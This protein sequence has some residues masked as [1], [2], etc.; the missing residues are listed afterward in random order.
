MSIY[1]SA[2]FISLIGL[3]WVGLGLSCKT[4]FVKLLPRTNALVILRAI[5]II[6]M[7]AIP[8]FDLKLGL[9][10]EFTERVPSGA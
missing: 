7:Y 10:A 3:G 9:I 4:L 5:Y 6:Q 8:I 2:K 1:A